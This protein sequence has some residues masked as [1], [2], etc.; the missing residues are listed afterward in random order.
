VHYVAPQPRDI[1]HFD[2]LAPLL[3]ELRLWPWTVLLM[4][5]KSHAGCLLNE[6]ADELADIG[7]KS[8][9]EPISPGPSKHGSVWIR[10][11]ESWRQRVSAEQLH[12]LP[13]DTARHSFTISFLGTPLGT[14]P[15]LTVEF[16]HIGRFRFRGNCSRPGTLR[17]EVEGIEIPDGRSGEKR[18]SGDR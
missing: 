16:R 5:F 9:V 14:Y 18:E 17:H 7:V 13:R 1:V 12:I 10:I 4:K 3:T 11:R 2:V 6:R 8:E 15:G